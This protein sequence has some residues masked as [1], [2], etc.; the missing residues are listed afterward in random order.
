MKIVISSSR[1]APEA[2][3]IKGFLI[4]ILE[5]KD[6]RVTDDPS[7]ERNHR[8]DVAYIYFCAD[9]QANQ[10]VS[11]Q[12]SEID[13][14]IKDADWVIVLAPLNHVGKYTMMEVMF[15][16]ESFYTNPD[17]NPVLTL[18]NC[19]DYYSDRFPENRKEDKGFRNGT[20]HPVF[21]E[22][23]EISIPCLKQMIEEKIASFRQ[24]GREQKEVYLG[25]YKY[26]SDGIGLKIA[27]REAFKKNYKDV[28]FRFQQL[29]G[30]AQPGSKVLAEQLYFDKQRADYIS[31]EYLPR[32]SV[33]GN[34]EQA[35]ANQRKFIIVT[36]L[37]GSGKTRAVLKLLK[38]NDGHQEN[39]YAF[40][41][42]SDKNVVVVDQKNVSEV[43]SRL[44]REK[45]HVDYL[46]RVKNQDV[47]PED[48]YL[49]CDQIKDVFSMFQ[50]LDDLSRFFSII[51][52]CNHIKFIATSLPDAYYDFLQRWGDRLCPLPKKNDFVEDQIIEI[53]LI[54]EDRNKDDIKNWIYFSLGVDSRVE[55]IGDC[56]KGLKN[57]KEK[58]VE[59]LYEK[60]ETD[61]TDKLPYLNVLMSSIQTV[62]TF[63]R[64]P[65]LFLPLLIFQKEIIDM[66]ELTRSD[67][68]DITVNTI[69][70]LI[71]NNVIWA[72]RFDGKGMAVGIDQINNNDFRLS[73]ARFEDHEDDFI[74]EEEIFLDTKMST[75]YVYGVNEIV[76][77][78]LKKVDANKHEHKLLFDYNKVDEIVES[79]QLYY[80]AVKRASTL[81]RILSRVPYKDNRSEALS[82]LWS[83][84]Y[85][86]IDNLNDEKESI[87]ELN[88]VFGMLIGLSSGMDDIEKVLELIEGKGITPNYSIIGQ[89]YI[90]GKDKPEDIKECIEKKVQDIRKRYHMDLNTLFSFS[91]EVSFHKLSFNEIIDRI[92]ESQFVNRA[93]IAM[94]IQ[95]FAATRKKD[96]FVSMN[97]DR[98]FSML[99]RKDFASNMDR[100]TR[101]L[102]L[103]EM[104]KLNMTRLAIYAF[105]QMA[106]KE[107]N[108]IVTMM[109]Y[110]LS[111]LPKKKVDSVKDV[112]PEGVDEEQIGMHSSIV[113]EDDLEYVFFSA[114]ECSENFKQAK[115]FFDIY[116]MLLQRLM[117]SQ[118]ENPRMVSI[119]LHN[120]GKYE[121]QQ[122]LLF[123][124]ETERR[125]KDEKKPFS[126][127][128]Y[129]N[130]L[131]KAP[132]VGEA[133]AVLP[134]ISEIQD[135][136][137]SNVLGTLKNRKLRNQKSD[138]NE[139]MVEQ[140]TDPKLFFYAYDVVMRSSVKRH[141]KSPSPFVLGLLYS[142]ASTLKQEAFI[143]DKY[144][145]VEDVEKKKLIDYSTTITSIRIKKPYRD[146]GTPEDKTDTSWGLFNKCRRFYRN[147]EWYI[148][149]DLYSNMM[150]KIYFA[151]QDDQERFSEQMRS[152]SH[153]IDE[154]ESL[155][156]KDEFFLANRYALDPVWNKKIFD[157]DHVSNEFIQDMKR[158]DIHK[159]RTLNKVLISLV[160]AGDVPFSKVWIFYQLIKGFYVKYPKRSKLKPDI[161]TFTNLLRAVKS[162]EDYDLVM[163]ELN[164]IYKKKQDEQKHNKK[165]NK[166]YEIF[167]A[168]IFNDSLKQAQM[169]VGCFVEDKKQDNDTDDSIDGI[170]REMQ[171]SF[172]KYDI[173]TPTTLNSDLKK[174]TE[175]KEFK[176]EDYNRLKKEVLEPN[177]KK[178]DYDIQ[179]YVSMIKLS[180]TFMEAKFWIVCLLADLNYEEYCNNLTQCRELASSAIM[181]RY[182]ID[183]SVA[184]FDY[185][186]NIMD[187][188]GYEPGNPDSFTKYSDKPKKSQFKN[189]YDYYWSTRWE[190]LCREMHDY[191][192]HGR[193]DKDR[194]ESIKEQI[195]VFDDHNVEMGVFTFKEKVVDIRAIIKEKL[196]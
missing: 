190:H 153:I 91:R 144:L 73:P 155:I 150:R 58:I 112:L 136:T 177:K 80:N 109:N 20:D 16:I 121:F 77:E 59:R 126:S 148:N 24:D 189:D 117:L 26:D 61:K 43:N 95:E 13:P 173:I 193:R 66:H 17:G 160:K 105:I 119:V 154:D 21:D 102:E 35:L 97:L 151:F 51:E 142:F 5:D 49:I 1:F 33:D 96:R 122:A 29:I 124:Q 36:G 82:R 55:S 182:S 11:M 140:K 166:K 81:R 169:R 4:D 115:A 118:K 186:K 87:D 134:S 145:L 57:Y 167:N 42:L 38:Q 170:L 195:Q 53:P 152:L 138:E 90:F 161:F 108:D 194:L 123:L 139:D 10:Q 37:P 94:S 31:N 196:K 178:I 104:C 79:A 30:L 67:A 65:H 39:Q 89:L 135:Y 92:K 187:D 7:E 120:V 76:W 137:I 107:S 191:C 168:E 165:H 111:L 15:A 40:G 106:A 130:L 133:L 164:E 162:K 88:Q 116:L 174:L 84:V 132:N 50:N 34:L 32:E 184:F 163:K 47:Q 23:N 176:N 127:I 72:A 64:E 12:D 192:F 8:Q 188:I 19:K 56:I 22:V 147:R 100:W 131:K 156:I 54:S 175:K 101:L 27:V 28:Q 14:E 45:D 157:R 158:S 103:Y 3:T 18:F 71:K 143:R 78:Y 125:Y 128:M 159:V 185:W 2:D 60:Y 74:C 99:A 172:S 141:R 110:V 63:R 181:A 180:P 70:Y 113:H 83:Y 46:K 41:A 98:T 129:N 93:G 149:S 9:H 62:E 44:L 6:I 48:I 68:I 52:D 179:S 86:K 25:E 75:K 69:N 171:I 183:N 146:I 85:K 114:I